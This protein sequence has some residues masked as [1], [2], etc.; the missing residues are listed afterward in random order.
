M[1]TEVLVD[2]LADAR[3][4]DVLD[5]V[6]DAPAEVV[7]ADDDGLAADVLAVGPSISF[8]AN[9]DVLADHILLH[10]LDLVRSLLVDGITY[11]HLEK[12]LV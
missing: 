4:D 11:P 5:D 10:L 9:A 3:L 8:S 12:F 7:L 6:I 2:V 1:I